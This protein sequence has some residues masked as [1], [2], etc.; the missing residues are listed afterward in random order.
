M[1][2]PSVVFVEGYVPFQARHVHRHPC[3]QV[4]HLS[5]GVNDGDPSL[6][7]RDQQQV[8]A[9]ARDRA[10]AAF[11][12]G[13]VER[14]DFSLQGVQ[15]RL[16]LLPRFDPSQRRRL[17]RFRLQPC[18]QKRFDLP[19]RRLDLLQ[20]LRP[21]RL[22]LLQ[23]LRP[24]RLDLLQR[25]RPRRLD[26]LQRPFL[27]RL[28]LRHRPA[29][30]DAVRQFGHRLHPRQRAERGVVV[31]VR[32]LDGSEP[33]DVHVFGAA[34]E[35]LREIVRHDGHDVGIR[36]RRGGRHARCEPDQGRVVAEYPA[37][38]AVVLHVVQQLR[39]APV[40]GV[41]MVADVPVL[42]C[43]GGRADALLRRKAG[44]RQEG[45]Q[46]EGGQG[47]RGRGH[48]ARPA[49]GHESVE[50]QRPRQQQGHVDG[51]H[52]PAVDG[53]I[54]G[55]GNRDDDE[56][57]VNRGE[58]AEGK[59]RRGPEG[60]KEGP[61]KAEAQGRGD[62][63]TGGPGGD[64]RGGQHRQPR[65]RPQEDVQA[66]RTREPRPLVEYAGHLPQR[67]GQRGP[68]DLA[69][70]PGQFAPV[71]P[72]AD[73]HRRQG[74]RGDGAED[75]GALQPDGQTRPRADEQQ[76]QNAGEYRRDARVAQQGGEGGET[77][78]P[79]QRRPGR[80][81]AQE[82]LQPD[83]RQQRQQ[84]EDRIGQE[85]RRVVVQRVRGENGQRGRNGDDGRPEAAPQP[86]A[87]YEDGEA[88]GGGVHQPAR[89]QRLDSEQPHEREE[90]RVEGRLVDDLA[91]EVGHQ[92]QP[93]E[94]VHGGRQVTRGVRGDGRAV[95][96]GADQDVQRPQGREERDEQGD[97]VR[98]E[99]REG[100][101][102]SEPPR[103]IL[104]MTVSSR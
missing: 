61:G 77:R 40:R 76:Q 59:G 93:G 52:V 94:Q 72:V 42:Q 62:A 2:T 44:M 37:L 102:E 60:G 67:V 16:N 26:L 21:R 87:G 15:Q 13:V 50:E 81:P 45:G 3:L 28:R 7:R 46:H 65:R 82:G 14:D 99:P 29:E 104:A 10:A 85:S 66:R 39:A 73:Q 47:V 17:P 98:P 33:D 55:G 41:V 101:G 91:S 49:R 22:D 75:G 9:Q 97:A 27:R 1:Q 103:M 6:R 20:R 12:P 4:V 90:H 54:D 63:E 31:S 83:Q 34:F 51:Q 71:Q 79:E 24:R 25:L 23:R 11:L 32:R 53:V 69:P 78:G 30:Y 80:L 64:H 56:R 88:E 38:D 36:V 18:R 89:F 43:P 100:A 57:R 35:P 8:V 95:G 58:H 84:D 92:P 5:L 96:G 70:L 86:Q 19:Q 74:N 48:A 68:R